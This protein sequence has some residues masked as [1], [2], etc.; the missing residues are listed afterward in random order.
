MSARPLRLIPLGVLLVA[1]P[2]ACSTVAPQWPPSTAASGAA[3]KGAAPGVEAEIGALLRRFLAAVDDP[4][5]HREFWADDLVYTSSGGERFGKE[6]ILGEL[7]GAPPPK[8]GD[9][10]ESY[11]AEEVRV[12]PLGDAALLTFKLVR[13]ATSKGETAT[14]RYWNTGVFV[15]RAGRWQAVA[16]Q[17]TKAQSQQS[18]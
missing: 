2:L 14:S 18:P 4:A 15:R 11:A 9:D 1:L 10:Q 3:A 16:W 8:P 7:A 17:A 12:Q 13:R 6:K 5:T